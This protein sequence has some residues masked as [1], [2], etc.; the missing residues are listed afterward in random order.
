MH[1]SIF[2]V[3]ELFKEYCY[4]SERQVTVVDPTRQI[5]EEELRNDGTTA[6]DQSVVLPGSSYE[7]SEEGMY[8]SMSKR[9]ASTIKNGNCCSTRKTVFLCLSCLKDLHVLFTHGCR[10]LNVT[11]QL[12]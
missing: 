12:A 9:L 11:D 7:P 8:I 4:I 3:L 6:D 5:S 2:R 10:K 1:F